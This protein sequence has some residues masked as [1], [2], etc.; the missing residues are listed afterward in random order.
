MD[1]T[2]G[3][4]PNP[5][6]VGSDGIVQTNLECDGFKVT[7]AEATVIPVPATRINQQPRSNGEPI[8][9]ASTTYPPSA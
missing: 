7:A 5:N 6:N 2:T 3:E 1:K 8:T 9:P 4:N